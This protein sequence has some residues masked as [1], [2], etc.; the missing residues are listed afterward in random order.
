MSLGLEIR[1]SLMK[2]K[3]LNSRAICI[4]MLENNA[5]L[6]VTYS[7]DVQLLHNDFIDMLHD[8]G[9]MAADAADALAAIYPSVKTAAEWK[10]LTN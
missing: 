5:N 3:G 7:N 4:A 10:A 6:R 1:Y 9:L 2:A 8:K